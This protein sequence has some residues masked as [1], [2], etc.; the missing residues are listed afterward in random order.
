MNL[1]ELKSILNLDDSIYPKEA[2]EHLIIKSLSMDEKLIP[3]L[4]NI[5]EQERRDKKELMSD[6]N[7]E[8]SRAHI[9]I[10]EHWPSNS[11]FAEQ[12]DRR[13]GR[14]VKVKEEKGLHRGFV[15]DKIAEFYTKYKGRISHCFN[16]FNDIPKQT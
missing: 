6:M 7:L 12:A 3:T 8:L 5:L 9:F 16:R 14:A 1:P 13:F 2:K 15:L 10:D 11:A 4:M